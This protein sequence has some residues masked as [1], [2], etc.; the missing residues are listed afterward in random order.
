MTVTPKL[1]QS[2]MASTLEAL[3]STIKDLSLEVEVITTDDAR[4]M[5]LTFCG[6]CSDLGPVHRTAANV[7]GVVIR[8]ASSE[9][10]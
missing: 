2:E 9:N 10:R 7:P 1:S 8:R 3:I 4:Y 5:S 6:N